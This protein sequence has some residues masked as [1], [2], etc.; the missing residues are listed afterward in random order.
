MG[1]QAH[2]TVAR[3][4]KN[5]VA[6]IIAVASTIVSKLLITIIIGRL[7][8][9]ERVGEF[10]FVMTFGLMFTFLSTAGMPWAMIREVATHRDQAHRYV[11]NGVTC[12]LG[13]NLNN[14]E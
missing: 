11:E 4:T 13:L 1:E 12:I 8:G 6:Q 5:A 9:A 14:L 10:A 7:F 3:V 2:R